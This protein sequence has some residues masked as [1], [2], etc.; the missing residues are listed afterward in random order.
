MVCKL[1]VIDLVIANFEQADL[2]TSN[3]YKLYNI[4]DSFEHWGTPPNMGFHSKN[5][6][7]ILNW[8]KNGFITSISSLGT[9]I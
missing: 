3:E 4:S 5:A 2:R 8:A 9:F 1:W 7:S 6:P